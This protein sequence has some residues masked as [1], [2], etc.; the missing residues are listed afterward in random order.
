MRSVYPSFGVLLLGGL[1]L[2]GCAVGGAKRRAA[3]EKQTA[4]AT[5]AGAGATNGAPVWQMRIGRVALVNS[6]LDFV[7]IDAGTSPAPAPGTRLRAYSEEEC[8]AELSVS[9][10]QQRPFLIADILSGKPRVS[11][12]VVPVK[13][14]PKPGEDRPVSKAGLESRATTPTGTDLASKDRPGS[15]SEPPLPQR[16]PPLAPPNIAELPQIERRPPPPAQS[17]L[18]P[19]RPPA[20]ESEAIIPGLPSPG[21]NAPR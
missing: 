3:L 8:S 17:L 13:G 16:Q 14:D 19:S 1:L 12:M 18:A 11:D 21:K 15:A 20:E 6:E 9:V 5:T 7:L 4:R 10:H 2:C